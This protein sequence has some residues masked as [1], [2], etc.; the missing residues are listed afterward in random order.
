MLEITPPKYCTACA[1][2]LNAC[3]KGAIKMQE[4]G[5]AGYV[6]PTIN[7]DECIDCHLCEKICPVNNPIEVHKPLKSYA[8]ISRSQDDLMTS[9]SGG[10]SSVMAQYILGQ[11][12]VVYGCVQENYTDIRH[13]R[14]TDSKDAFKL[15]GSKYVQSD[16][17]YVYRQVKQDLVCGL[18]VLFTGT[19]CQIA[20]LRKYLHRDYDNLYLVDLV[21]HGVPSQKILRDSVEDMAGKVEKMSSV[22]FRKKGTKPQELRFG[23]FL[24]QENAIP[25]RKQLFPHNDYIA[26]FMAGLIFRKNCFSCSY[27]QPS[28]GS[29]VTIADYW[30]I[31][32]TA[33]PIG[34]GISLMLANTPKGISLINNISS[35]CY[36]EERTVEEAVKGN[37]QLNHPSVEPPFRDDFLLHYEK[38][39]KE[40]YKLY[41]KEYR[42]MTKKMKR[43]EAMIAFI[44]KSDM[45]YQFVYKMYRLILRRN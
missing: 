31:G 11:G 20:G 42:N 4:Y 15:K 37:G 43:R 29:D 9:T 14:I 18:K 8:A 13:Q 36:I 23:V 30:G 27:A 17:G 38:N 45:I 33:I 41:L 24:D 6:Y 26:A 1:A 3:P 34:R 10:A 25:M 40:A 5:I 21:C 12:G 7:Q 2:C 19:P 22:S 16:I 35:L 28:R 32:E 39:R 44:K